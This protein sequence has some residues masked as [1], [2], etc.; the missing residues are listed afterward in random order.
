MGCDLIFVLFVRYVRQISFAS[1]THVHNT[2]Y[3]CYYW[4]RL[5][6]SKTNKFCFLLLY[7]SRFARNVQIDGITSYIITK[8]HL[9]IVGNVYLCTHFREISLFVQR[10]SL[11]QTF[12]IYYCNF[13]LIKSWAH[14]SAWGQ[15][16][17]EFEKFAGNKISFQ[18]PTDNGFVSRRTYH[19]LWYFSG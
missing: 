12:P 3:Y 18:N 6:L 2:Y 8:W 13:R 7:C 11:W 19:K 14:F 9:V 4:Q 17:C 5:W 16:R 10:A 15:N 1:Y